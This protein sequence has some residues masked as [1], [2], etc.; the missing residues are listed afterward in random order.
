MENSSETKPIGKLTVEMGE[1]KYVLN[2]G[3]GG[4]TPGIPIP[5]DTVNSDSII[6]GSVDMVDLADEVKD[7]MVTGDDRVTQEDLD[8]FEV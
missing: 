8:R 4:V 2:G 3:G 6:D 7:E 1:N 5:K